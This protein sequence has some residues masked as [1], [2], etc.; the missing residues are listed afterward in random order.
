MFR[1]CYNMVCNTKRLLMWDWGFW[2]GVQNISLHI[3]QTSCWNLLIIEL[4][5]K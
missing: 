5:C 3:S 1:I 4:S 2:R